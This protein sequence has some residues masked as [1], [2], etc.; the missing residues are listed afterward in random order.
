MP[1]RS[2]LHQGA[3][4]RKTETKN[5]DLKNRLMAALRICHMKHEEVPGPNG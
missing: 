1:D 3:H 5:Y 2:Y 4:E